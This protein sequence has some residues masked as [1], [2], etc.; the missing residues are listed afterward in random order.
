MN[1]LLIAHLSDT[2]LGDAAILTGTAQLVRELR[3]DAA[4]A[5]APGMP[6]NALAE[7]DTATARREGIEVLAPLCAQ[8][9]RGVSPEGTIALHG[10]ALWEAARSLALLLS[11]RAGGRLLSAAER[12]TLEAYRRADLLVVEGGSSLRAEGR[13]SH[14]VHVWRFVF[15]VLLGLR[16]RKRVVGLGHSL[17]PIERGLP[18]AL[19][20]FALRR[21]WT[22]YPRDPY[23]QELYR[24]IT[25]RDVPWIPDLSLALRP[26]SP[27]RNGHEGRRVA[28]S[29]RPLEGSREQ[30]V[31]DRLVR[32]LELLDPRPDEVAVIANAFGPSPKQDDRPVL[33]RLERRLGE[34]GFNVTRAEHRDPHSAAGD[35]GRFDAVFGVRMHAAILARIAGAPSVPLD[36]EGSKAAGVFSYLA[37]GVKVE[38]VEGDFA[39]SVAAQVER[40][41][42][43]GLPAEERAALERSAAELRRAVADIL[44]GRR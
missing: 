7:R 25:G 16:L 41:L 39:P 24:K 22:I 38:R 12:R 15:P 43:T 21:D 33:E 20:R 34:R 11:P 19:L 26:P 30:A 4:I 42:A 18:G 44:D 35:Y 17:G 40:Y 29:V 23:S 10:R 2:N 32:V 1:V 13:L 28:V 8:P 36:Y 9:V 27:D 5:L 14:V 37:P 6:A 3:P 31:E